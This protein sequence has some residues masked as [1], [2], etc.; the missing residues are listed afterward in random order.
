MKNEVRR[1]TGRLNLALKRVTELC[2]LFTPQSGYCRLDRCSAECIESCKNWKL[3]PL[4][5]VTTTE[6]A[7]R[8]I[9]STSR[10]ENCQLEQLRA[11]NVLLNARLSESVQII[12]MLVK[13]FSNQ[14]D[15]TSRLGRFIRYIYSVNDK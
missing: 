6:K 7:T 2:A 10:N 15:K 5:Q 8:W 9:R 4:G 3:E 14:L 13:E 12:K 11:D 1:L